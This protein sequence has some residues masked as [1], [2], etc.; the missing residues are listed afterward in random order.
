MPRDDGFV[1]RSSNVA[2]LMHATSALA[3][4]AGAWNGQYVR[5][6]W[7]PCGRV[8]A[9][10]EGIEVAARVLS[11]GRYGPGC[12]YLRAYAPELLAEFVTLRRT[13]LWARL[14]GALSYGGP[15]TGD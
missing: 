15:R 2:T 13:S 5:P 12:T 10:V 4:A 6:S 1:E 14:G 11:S 7:R 9:K 8:D 3:D